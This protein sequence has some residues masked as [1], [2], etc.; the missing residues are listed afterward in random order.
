VPKQPLEYNLIFHALADD[1]RR[2]VLERLGYGPATAS[3]LAAPFDMALPSFMQHLGVLERSGLVRSSK[4]GRVR[5]YT[6]EPAA[7][8]HIQDW[9][10]NQR[11]IWERRFDQLE[12]LFQTQLETQKENQHDES[13][14]L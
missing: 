14:S 3:Q 7:L 5:T 1:T 10:A 4:T 11:N 12:E 2:T 6:L 9:L 13:T 8:H